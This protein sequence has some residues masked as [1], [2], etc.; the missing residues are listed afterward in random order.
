MN[1]KWKTLISV[2]AMLIPVVLKV[3]ERMR[4]KKHYA[5]YVLRHES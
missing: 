3:T 5:S 1:S 4:R 2:A